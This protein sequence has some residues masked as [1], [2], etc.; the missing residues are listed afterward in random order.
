[1]AT[2][3]YVYQ[4]AMVTGYPTHERLQKKI[5]MEINEVE[6]AVAISDRRRLGTNDYEDADSLDK[7]VATPP[8]KSYTPS[9]YLRQSR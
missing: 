6:K 9:R 4:V 5:C 3:R 8:V 2:S 1:M 7:V